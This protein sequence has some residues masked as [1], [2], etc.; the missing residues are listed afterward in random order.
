MPTSQKPL[1]TSDELATAYLSRRI[2][3]EVFQTLCALAMNTDGSPLWLSS[4][5]KNNR[6]PADDLPCPSKPST[7]AGREPA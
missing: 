3:A 5:T 7:T 2:S 1:I 6:H 4:K